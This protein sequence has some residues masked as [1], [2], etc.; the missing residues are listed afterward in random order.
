MKPLKLLITLLIILIIL[1]VI[2]LK[3]N[4]EPKIIVPE[5]KVTADKD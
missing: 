4:L 1:L 5:I 2:Y 3:I